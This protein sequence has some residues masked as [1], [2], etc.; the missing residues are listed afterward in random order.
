MRVKI[1]QKTS[2]NI[3]LE[4]ILKNSLL[5]VAQARQV[6]KFTI[7]PQSINLATLTS[8]KDLSLVWLL[9]KF[10][11]TGRDLLSEKVCQRNFLQMSLTKYSKFV[12]LN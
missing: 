5:L 10:K 2:L 9:L 11:L 3:D 12:S 6:H 8:Y 1:R 7:W 4:F